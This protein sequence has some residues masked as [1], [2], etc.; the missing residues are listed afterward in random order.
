M[1]FATALANAALFTIVLAEIDPIVIKFRERH[2]VVDAEDAEAIAKAEVVYDDPLA[3]P[4]GCQRDIPYLQ[5][6]NTNTIRVYAIDPSKNH[7]E[8][9]DA[10]ADAGIYVVADL[11]EPSKSINRDSPTWD[12]QLYKRYTSV[13]DAMAKYNNLLGFF[14][15]N[16]VTNNVTNTVASA[17]VKAAVRDSKTYIKSK[18]YR[19]IGVGY[20]T[21]DDADIRMNLA[22]YFN[23][24]DRIEDSVDF[25]GYNV[26]SWC[27]NSSFA[28]SGWDMLVKNFSLVKVTKDKLTKLPDFNNLKEQIVEVNPEGVKMSNYTPVN[29]PAKCP[30]IGPDWLASPKLPPPP[31]AEA[32]KCKVNSLS[33]KLKNTVS[34]K[35][36]ASLFDT[37]YGFG[38]QFT[39]DIVAN[40]TAGEYGAFSMCDPRDQLSIAMD[41]Y[42]KE[43]SKKGL[44][45]GGEACN[46][47]GAAELRKANKLSDTCEEAI[48]K[49]VFA[50]N[51]SPSSGVDHTNKDSKTQNTKGSS[52]DVTSGNAAGTVPIPSFNMAGLFFL[53]ACLIAPTFTGASIL[54]L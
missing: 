15:G 18:E 25:W 3:D 12:V 37:V 11:S 41:V 54:F 17:F 21:N 28:E 31:N 16:E 27:G 43:Q 34:N 49:A 23:C 50:A 39:A 19:D 2:D 5:Q 42:Y 40:A 46:F 10:L 9:M 4:K 6:L 33:C 24:G 48:K 36:L 29:K 51:S 8:C 20:A 47:D 26:Y 35:K 30:N 14:A 7:D 53:I 32:C 45:Q 1:K 44:Y 52:A 13:I 38:S 22:H